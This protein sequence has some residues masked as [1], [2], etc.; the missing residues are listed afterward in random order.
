[1]T[2]TADLPIELVA[3]TLEHYARRGVFKGFSRAGISRGKATFR[4]AWHLGRVFDLTVDL[5]TLEMRFPALLPNLPA[6]SSMY[7]RLKEFIASR[8]ATDL[9]EHRRIDGSRARIRSYNRSGNVSLVLR[10]KKDDCEYGT[11]KLVHLVH[12]IF[13]TFLADGYLD[14]MVETFD[15]D[16][17]RV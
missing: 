7:R 13:L 9:P 5:K 6:D 10:M 16:P 15:L 17:D 8:H 1:V 2:K 14:Y 12:E 11:R 4:I 3:E